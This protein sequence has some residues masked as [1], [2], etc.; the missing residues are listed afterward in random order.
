MD[1]R[2]R[3]LGQKERGSCK[4]KDVPLNQVTIG[5]LEIKV[6]SLLVLA[7]LLRLFIVGTG[8]RLTVSVTW[9][10]PN[11]PKPSQGKDQLEILND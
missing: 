9:P 6:N 10:G 3:H 8:L 2:Q 1:Q 5:A 11:F 4:K 7:Y